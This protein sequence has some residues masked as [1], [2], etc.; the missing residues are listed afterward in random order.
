MSRIRALVR[1]VP[2]AAIIALVAALTA[3]AVASTPATAATT[4]TFDANLHTAFKACVANAGQTADGQFDLRG[5]Y[6]CLGGRGYTAVAYAPA[7]PGSLTT[8]IPTPSPFEINI[9]STF[10]FCLMEASDLDSLYPGIHPNEVNRCLED[11]G[12][13]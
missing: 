2:L 10:T 11:H 5:F 12:I 13:L 7:G 4:S 1:P 9:F 3:A 6:S 8:R